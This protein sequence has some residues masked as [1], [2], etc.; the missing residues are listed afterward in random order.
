[1]INCTPA[2]YN[3]LLTQVGGQDVITLETMKPLLDEL[4]GA[5]L[6][7]LGKHVKMHVSIAKGDT[8]KQCLKNVH[9]L[10]MVCLA[11]MALVVIVSPRAMAADDAAKLTPEQKAL[12]QTGILAMKDRT[13]EDLYKE[14]PETREQIANAVGYAVF[15]AT[16]VYLLLYVAQEGAGV[17]IDKSDAKPT[18]MTLLRAGTG[19]GVGYQSFRL[20]LVFKTKGLMDQFKKVG[21]DVGASGA[22]TIKGGGYGTN[23]SGETSFNPD[24]SVY[25]ITDKG[26]ALQAN[27]GATAFLPD[28][29]LN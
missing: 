5:A 16:G 6:L 28:E 11:A 25:Q 22:F 29:K 17:L 18:Y 4:A 7:D 24:L 8:M 10:M 1:M 15:D 3:A 23:I 20:V 9:K 12:R 26:I 27:W 2:S 21:A 14:K 19:P 13:L